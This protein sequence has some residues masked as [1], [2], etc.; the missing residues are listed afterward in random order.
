MDKILTGART[1]SSARSVKAKDFWKKA[2]LRN[3]L[4]S[5]SFVPFLRLRVESVMYNTVMCGFLGDS[6]SFRGRF[7][8]HTPQNNENPDS[9]DYGN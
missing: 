3:E 1:C 2:L 6:F 8:S 7:A 9:L 5:Y 4:F